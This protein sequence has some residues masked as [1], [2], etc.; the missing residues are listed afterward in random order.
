MEFSP[1]KNG[2]T[3]MEN[4]VLAVLGMARQGPIA[5]IEDQDID[6]GKTGMHPGR[7]PVKSSCK[8]YRHHAQHG[9]THCAHGK[10]DERRNGRRTCLSAPER[11]ERS[12]SPLRKTSKTR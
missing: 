5:Q 9:Q 1:G 7:Q 10:A 6:K 11:A 8:G 2:I 3:A 12:D 4:D